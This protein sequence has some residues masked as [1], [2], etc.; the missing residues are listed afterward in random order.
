MHSDRMRL[1][2]VKVSQRWLL[3]PRTL[4][5]PLVTSLP[6]ATKLGQGYIFTG[7]C[8]SVHRGGACVVGGACA[9]LQGACMICQG[10]CVVAGGAC[11]VARG[12][13][14]GC[15]GV[16]GCWGECIAMG[17]VW[18]GA[19][20]VARGC[21]WLRGACVVAGGMHGC[22]GGV[23]GC[24]GGM[25][26]AR[27]DTVNERAVCIPLECILVIGLDTRKLLKILRQR[28]KSNH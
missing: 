11:V 3:L 22:R 21:A 6:P 25:C 5:C 9:W 26:R 8:D 17:G 19:C 10:A 27:R 13:M 16:C 23:C 15:R 18:L 14:H 28:G 1:N 12:G 2:V 20:L 24:K 7:V 4:S